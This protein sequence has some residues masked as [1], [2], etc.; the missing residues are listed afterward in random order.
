MFTVGVPFQHYPDHLKGYMLLG[1]LNVNHLKNMDEAQLVS[2][3][4][5]F[6]NY[7][8]GAYKNHI[9]I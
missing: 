8:I 3:L 4:P 9:K 1:E 5:W 2:Y 6:V 7:I